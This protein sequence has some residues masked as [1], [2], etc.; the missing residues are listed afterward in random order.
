[1]IQVESSTACDAKCVFCPVGSKAHIK[2][3]K[4]GYM[5]DSVF[6]K[7]LQEASELGITDVLPFL[8]GEPLIFPGLF[9]WLDMMRGYGLKCTLF[10][11]GNALDAENARLLVDYPH[12]VRGVIFSVAGMDDES[13]WELMGLDHDKV[14]GNIEYFLKVNK[15]RIRVYAHMPLFSLTSG[16]V[17]AWTAY[18]REIIPNAAPTVLYNYAGLI[19]DAL[20]HK[21]DGL[22]LRQ[23]CPRLKHATILH[24]G[25]VCLCCMDAQGQ[26]VFGNMKENS[27]FDIYNSPEFVRYRQLHAQGRFAELALCRDCNMNILGRVS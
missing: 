12:V 17:G 19:R 26:V 2:T 18:W 16:W 1:M 11:N 8:N 14:Y 7:I 21:E 27:I 13:H 9:R 10:T 24:N 6:E 15:S 25:D 5:R 3:R 23:A 20:E 22:H 4:S